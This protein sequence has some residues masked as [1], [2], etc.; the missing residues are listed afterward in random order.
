MEETSEAS[1][2]LSRLGKNLANLACITNLGKISDVISFLSLFFQCQTAALDELF[3]NPQ[4]VR[5]NINW[6]HLEKT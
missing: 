2:D 1:G 4:E 3:N 5:S 6:P